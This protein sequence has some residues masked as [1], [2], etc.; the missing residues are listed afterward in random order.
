MSLV[1]LLLPFPISLPGSS[2]SAWPISE[3][4]SSLRR[5]HVSPANRRV[6]ELAHS[7]GLCCSV[8]I[9]VSPGFL[10]LG[11]PSAPTA[12]Q[13]QVRTSPAGRGQR[14]LWLS[15]SQPQL[16]T[17]SLDLFCSPSRQLP[18]WSPARILCHHP[19]PCPGLTHPE[20][21]PSRHPLGPLSSPH[22]PSV[23]QDH[24]RDQATLQPPS[25]PSTS[26]L[27]PPVRRLL[28]HL[29]RG[30]VPLP[31]NALGHG[32]ESQRGLLGPA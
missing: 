24:L 21:F 13:V 7:H 3:G 23:S 20:L 17:P 9:P 26:T 22:P 11:F 25:C 18:E 2:F 16:L 4:A 19:F 12:T 10:S 5:G 32:P 29:R 15:P 28:P 6:G 8:C 27:R 30:Q 31:Q 14:C 1:P